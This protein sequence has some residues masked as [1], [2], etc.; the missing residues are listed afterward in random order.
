MVESEARVIRFDNVVVDDAD[1]GAGE[2]RDFDDEDFLMKKK[3]ITRNGCRMEYS[4]FFN[5]FFSSTV[6]FR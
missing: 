2:D 1:A 4:C 3:M 5:F 6:G